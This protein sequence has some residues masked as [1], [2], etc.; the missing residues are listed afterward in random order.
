VVY[1]GHALTPLNILGS[2]NVGTWNGT[3]NNIHWHDHSLINGVGNIRDAYRFYFPGDIDNVLPYNKHKSIVFPS[4]NA[5][6]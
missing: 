1:H 6:I 4:N 3:D 5:I 2:F